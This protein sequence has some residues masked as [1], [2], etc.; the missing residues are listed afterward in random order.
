MGVEEPAGAPVI[1]L[2]GREVGHA[3][4]HSLVLRE[5]QSV[6]QIALPRVGP[7]RGIR[8]AM[9]GHPPTELG[10]RLR[11]WQPDSAHATIIA[12]IKRLRGGHRPS[13]G[14]RVV[15]ARDVRAVMQQST[16]NV[17]F[18]PTARV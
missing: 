5:V 11:P 12:A 10:S 1:V 4:A 17:P 7:S 13:W 6:L 3:P 9:F 2:P 18:R 15:H 16:Q 8:A 14:T